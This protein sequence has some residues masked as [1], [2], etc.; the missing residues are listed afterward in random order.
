MV[1]R[2]KLTRAAIF[3]GATALATPACGGS[4]DADPIEDGDDSW[5]G[6]RTLYGGPAEEQ[7]GGQGD[8]EPPPPDPEDDGYNLEPAYGVPP[9]PG[10][11]GP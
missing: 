11:E 4:N 3:L 2:A 5:G 1:P 9:D 10:P 6:E 8:V 7:G